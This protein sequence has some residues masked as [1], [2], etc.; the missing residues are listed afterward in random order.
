[1]ENVLKFTKMGMDIDDADYAGDI[2]N[3]RIRAT[4]TVNDVDFLIEITAIATLQKTS[5]KTGE[6]LKHPKT[7]SYVNGMRVEIIGSEK[8]LVRACGGNWFMH[9]EDRTIFDEM[10]TRIPS[11]KKDYALAVINGQLQ[12]KFDSIEVA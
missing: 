6:P 9:D 8:R 5:E 12:T 3:H 1:M 7:T 4:V 2:G 11:H 10:F